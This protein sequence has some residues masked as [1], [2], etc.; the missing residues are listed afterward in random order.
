MLDEYT[1]ACPYC[2]ESFSTTLDTSAGSQDYIED[3]QICCRPILFCLTLD[4][5]T[6]QTNVELRRDDD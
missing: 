1:A 5:V 4:P 3:C 6:D 2:G